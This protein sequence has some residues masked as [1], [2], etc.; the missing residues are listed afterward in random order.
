M[1]QAAKYIAIT[2]DRS[3]AKEFEVTEVETM[4]KT[5]SNR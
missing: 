1:T 5:A 4:R 2:S 3:S